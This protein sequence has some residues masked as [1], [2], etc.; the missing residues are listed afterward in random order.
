MSAYG[1]DRV[2]SGYPS[3]NHP[4]DAYNPWPLTLK[5]CDIPY[6]ATNGT[7]SFGNVIRTHAVADGVKV[8]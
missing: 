5:G 2:Y 8:R 1:P 3:D 6:E 7:V 4:Q